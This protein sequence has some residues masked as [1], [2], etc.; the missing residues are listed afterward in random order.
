MNIP[1]ISIPNVETAPRQNRST[2][3][4]GE[5]ALSL[6]NSWSSISASLFMFSEGAWVVRRIC[7]FLWVDD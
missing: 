7:D 5:Y 4:Q 3:V 6:R 2:S 1:A